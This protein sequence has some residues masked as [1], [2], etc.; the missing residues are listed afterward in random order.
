MCIRDSPVTDGAYDTTYNGGYYDAFAAKL[1]PTGTALLY[2]TFLGGD[3]QEKGVDVEAD[4]GGNAYV[5]GWTAS[6]DFPSVA[7]ASGF[8]VYQGGETD[9]FVAKLN[10]AG[11]A[12]EYALFVGGSDLDVGMALAVDEG[13][14]AYVTGYTESADFPWRL[15]S[16]YDL[17]GDVDAFLACVRP[18]GSSLFYST[19]LGGSEDDIGWDIA[20]DEDGSAYVVGATDSTDFP[21]TPGAFDTSYNGGY[22]DAFVAKLSAGTLHYATYLGEDGD[23]Q[24]YGLAV[25]AAGSAHVTGALGDDAITRLDPTGSSVDYRFTV[26]GFGE[27]EGDAIAVDA[28]GGIY[29]LGYTSYGGLPVT[30]GAWDDTAYY[31]DVWLAKVAPPAHISGRVTDSAGQPLAGIQVAASGVF[32]ATTDASGQYTLTVPAG[33]HAFAPTTSG[34]FWSPASRSAAVPP[35]ATGQD[36]VGKG[37]AKD[38]TPASP[39]AAD[40]GSTLTYTVR[41]VAPENRT[42]VL[43]DPVPTY[44]NFVSG[45]LSGPVGVSYDA[46]ANAIGGVVSVTADLPLTVTFRVQVGIAGTAGWAPCIVNR[47]CVHPVGSALTTCE[48]SN[49]TTTYTYLWSVYLPLILR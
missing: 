10:A 25:D 45:S 32:S 2:A 30:P 18:S 28:Q 20:L 42:V 43:H 7:S 13:S 11:S 8:D 4:D 46:V 33:I 15:A 26:A 23:E 21:V 17:D 12:L 16:D 31:E 22:S 39:P 9:V 19:Y 36:F 1:N 44:T 37:V 47:A 6:A 41:L 29:V 14:Y 40:Y 38:V 27:G 3:D 35:A 24:G 5:T 48:W 49:E 34:Y